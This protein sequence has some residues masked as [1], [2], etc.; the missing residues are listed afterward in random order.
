VREIRSHVGD[1]LF[2]AAEVIEHAR[3]VPA[4]E[5]ALVAA[6]GGL[7]GR[8]LGH[9]LARAEGADCG[10]VAVARIVGEDRDGAIWAVRV[11]QAAN[12][13][14]SAQTARRAV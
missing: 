4:L 2:T 13:L 5:Q 1:A 3:R 7:N 6:L 14:P 8:R 12:P 10:G 9:F 11:L